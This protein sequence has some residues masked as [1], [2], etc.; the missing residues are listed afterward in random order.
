MQDKRRRQQMETKKCR[1]SDTFWFQEL[2]RPTVPSLAALPATCSKADRR[3]TRLRARQPAALREIYQHKGRRWDRSLGD[4][5]G[6]NP[7]PARLLPTCR[8]LTPCTSL[9]YSPFVP[10]HLSVDAAAVWVP[11]ERQTNGRELITII[12]YLTLFEKRLAE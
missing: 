5:P 2:G 6:S 3:R 4:D 7:I 11:V 1:S 10:N 12:S 8:N 9:N